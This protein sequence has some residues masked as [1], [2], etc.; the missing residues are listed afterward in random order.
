MASSLIL[1]IKEGDGRA[2]DEIYKTWKSQFIALFR[3]NQ[4]LLQVDA[5]DL[6][7]KACAI[8]LN[9][10]ETG[11]LLA[12]AIENSQIKAYLNNTGKFILYN[13]R[14]KR[15]TPLTMDSDFIIR[16]NVGDDSFDTLCN[17]EIDKEK[18]DKL[19]IIRTT[20]RDMPEPCASILNLAVYHKKSN[21]EVAEILHY[22]GADSVKTQR[23]RCMKKL[24][25][26]VK[27]RFKAAG[28]EQ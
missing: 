1:R 10:I 7:H 24:S 19:F 16:Y 20:V 21:A 27:E 2:F 13:E 3:K 5:E 18:D 11:K 15:Q 22:A 14:R 28:Y 6:Y 17:K 23:S 4:G 25:D 9:N 26:K 8:L 12:E